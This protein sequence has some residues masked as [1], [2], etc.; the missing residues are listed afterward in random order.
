MMMFF[1]LGG[2]HYAFSE[3]AFAMRCL[4][5]L[6]SRSI[7]TIAGGQATLS[8]VAF[9]G[10]G[11]TNIKKVIAELILGSVAF[12]ADLSADGTSFAPGITEDIIGTRDVSS[13]VT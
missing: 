2:Q 13:A 3:R 10:A 12:P 1:T 11:W 9:T 5:L 6:G 7:T 4:N 8:S